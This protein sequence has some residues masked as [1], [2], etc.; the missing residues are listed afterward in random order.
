MEVP[1]Q[2]VI[3]SCREAT[4][5]LVKKERQT[6]FLP[7]YN[8]GRKPGSVFEVLAKSIKT[9]TGCRNRCI[10][11]HT[12]FWG[13]ANYNISKPPLSFWTTSDRLKKIPPC[14]PGKTRKIFRK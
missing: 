8:L 6:G 3:H 9:V 12:T 10:R 4:R 1:T 7:L 11:A 5:M 2:A 14:H 13:K